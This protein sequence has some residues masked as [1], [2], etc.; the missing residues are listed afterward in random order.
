M[1]S[2]VSVDE[3]MPEIDGGSTE[4]FNVLVFSEENGVQQAF[5]CYED[6]AW[7]GHDGEM[8][9]SELGDADCVTHWMPLPDPPE[10]KP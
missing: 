5:Y 7:Y 3:R 4:T 6:D 10:V 9:T 1:T 2:W 8:I